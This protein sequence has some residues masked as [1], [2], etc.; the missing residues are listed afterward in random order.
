M[1]LQQALVVV[2]ALSCVSPSIA[3]ETAPQTTGVKMAR[4]AQKYVASLS[5]EQRAKGIMS[6]DDPRRLDWHN[7]PKPER[8]GLQLRD[9][10]ADQ[11]KLVHELLKDSL[12]ETGYDKAVKILAL[13]NNL[14][15]GEKNRPGSP[16]RDA[17]RYFLTIFGE[18]SESGEWGWSFEG[19]HFSVNFVVRDGQVVA[20]TPS[21]WAQ[22]RRPCTH[23]S[24]A[25]R[26]W[27]HARW[28]TKNNLL[29]TC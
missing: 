12:S 29:S 20:D 23:L 19:H 17:Q 2:L 13:E 14:H 27:A 6:F 4:A 21:F 1:K 16:L 24:K 25:V 22:I 15:E 10:S 7:I 3:K 26:R 5:P 8:K 11:Q 28:P 9:L 18:P